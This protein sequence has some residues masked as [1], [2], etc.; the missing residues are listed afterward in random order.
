M[1]HQ[2]TIAELISINEKL[3]KQHEEDVLTITKLTAPMGHLQKMLF[4]PKTEKKK[5][6]YPDDAD[7]PEISLFNE[8]EVESDIPLEKIPLRSKRQR[9]KRTAERSGLLS[10]VK[11]SWAICLTRR[12]YMTSWKKRKSARHADIPW[13]PWEKN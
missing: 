2:P 1:S 10:P 6:L 13:F 9:S 3:K 4:A 8:A 12:S 7:S 5:V 11:R